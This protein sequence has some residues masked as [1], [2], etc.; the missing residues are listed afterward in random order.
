MLE[1]TEFRGRT[2]LGSGPGLSVP[3]KEWVVVTKDRI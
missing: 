3:L 1:N 2:E